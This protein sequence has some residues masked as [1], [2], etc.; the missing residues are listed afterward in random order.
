MPNMLD[1]F[2]LLRMRRRRVLCVI[3]IELAGLSGDNDISMWPDA[4]INHV[5]LVGPNSWLQLFEWDHCGQICCNLSSKTSLISNLEF[6]QDQ[7]QFTLCCWLRT[8]WYTKTRY[9]VY[10]LVQLR[11]LC[12]LES[13]SAAYLTKLTINKVRSE[14]QRIIQLSIASPRSKHHQAAPTTTNKLSH[15]TLAGQSFSLELRLSIRI[16]TEEPMHD[17]S[18]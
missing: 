2:L 14:C 7:L 13:V 5:L 11:R 18:L 8:L 16:I 17:L 3:G 15:Q 4:T 10:N 1:L 12:V 6:L 9:V